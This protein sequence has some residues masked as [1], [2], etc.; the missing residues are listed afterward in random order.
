MVSDY[1]QFYTAAANAFSQDSHSHFA[2]TKDESAKIHFLRQH[3]H[4]IQITTI[5]TNGVEHIPRGGS[6]AVDSLIVLG[7]IPQDL[8]TVQACV[9]KVD[10]S[11]SFHPLYCSALEPL[12][13]DHEHPNGIKRFTGRLAA[14]NAGRFGFSVRVVPKLEQAAVPVISGLL[15]WAH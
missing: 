1:S 14:P 13:A 9:G 2:V 3:W 10:A 5:S 15:T 11:G 7:E 8:I 12:A 6:L 4:Q